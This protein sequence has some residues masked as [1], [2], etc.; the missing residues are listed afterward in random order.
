MI[1]YSR[2]RKTISDILISPRGI[3]YRF[4]KEVPHATPEAQER[5]LTRRMLLLAP[6]C[7]KS[8]ERGNLP[9]Y[10]PVTV[11]FPTPSHVIVFII[12]LYSLAQEQRFL[13]C[14]QF[15]M[16]P[17]S[18]ELFAGYR[19][20]NLSIYFFPGIVMDVAAEEKLFTVILLPDSVERFSTE[21]QVR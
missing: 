8:I 12:Q 21:T 2:W 4:E 19:D 16:F 15:F 10:A 14:K 9:V 18:V 13:F 11:F 1:I 5:W 17:D 3:N 20:T 6:S 7:S